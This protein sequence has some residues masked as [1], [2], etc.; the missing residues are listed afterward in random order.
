MDIGTGDTISL[1]QIAETF[2]TKIIREPELKGYAVS[3]Q[4]DIEPARE[5]LGWIPTVRIL[6]WINSVLN[7]NSN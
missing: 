7:R 5:Q 6:N 3:T 4:A 2:N 1:N